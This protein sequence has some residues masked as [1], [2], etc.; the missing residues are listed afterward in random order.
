MP[1]KN[2]IT[3]S[4]IVSSETP[5]ALAG[6]IANEHAERYVF[7]EYQLRLSSNTR[8]RQSNDL[9]LFVQYLTLA[10]VEVTVDALLSSPGAWSGMTH[11]LIDG[12]V[13]Y[14]LQ[15]GYAIGSINVRLSTIKRYCSLAARAGTLSP[16]D[17]GLITLVKGYRHKEGRN[18]DQAREQTRQKRAKKAEPISISPEQVKQLKAQPDTPQ[19][20]RDTLLMC[21]L[22]DHG[23]RCG[24][25]ADLPV[26]AI[27]TH[28]GMLTFYRAKVDK[29][30]THTVTRDT[31]IAALR[32]FEVCKPTEQ[33]LMGSHKGGAMSGHMSER[34]ITKRVNTL[35]KAIDVS[36][37]SAHDG[38]HAWATRAV[39]AGTNIKTL[40]DAGGWSSIAMPARYAASQTI[41]N[42]GVKLD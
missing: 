8:R 1:E 42:E 22:F 16:A 9:A 19:G 34:A 28:T 30:Q 12:F 21:L 38:R 5:M 26:T 20:R 7:S 36:G 23:L 11:G 29:V 37:A 27:N 4:D 31:L 25:I 24:E 14:Q 17:M 2:I 13:R 18:I 10:R 35:C 40:Q 15:Q 39:R 6:A 41:A 33:L 32:Y 3:V